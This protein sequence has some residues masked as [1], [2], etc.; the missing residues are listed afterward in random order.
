MR[1]VFIQITIPQGSYEIESLNN[2]I[3]RN[4][5]DESHFT[6]ADHP[7]T[8]KPNFSTPGSIITI[9]AQGPIITFQTDDSIRDLLGFN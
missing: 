6:E 4:I 8:I 7:F 9:F 1:I 3:E 2:G 5:I